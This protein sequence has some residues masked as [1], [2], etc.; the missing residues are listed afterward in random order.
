M[1]GCLEQS[2]RTD[3]PVTRQ[4]KQGCLYLVIQIQITLAVTVVQD[5]QESTLSHAYGQPGVKEMGVIP[6]DW[7]E[8]WCT[9]GYSGIHRNSLDLGGIGLIMVY[10]PPQ[11]VSSSS[12]Q[13]EQAKSD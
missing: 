10:D 7:A 9:E 11:V 1:V 3:H 12:E 6:C 4:W 13:L 2:A 5:M 8:C